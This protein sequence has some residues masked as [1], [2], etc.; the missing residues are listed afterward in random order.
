MFTEQGLANLLLF[1]IETASVTEH[2]T[3]LPPRLQKLWEKRCDYLR[4]RDKHPENKELTNEQLFEN[5]AGLHAEFGR[6]VCVSV[7]MIRFTDGKPKLIQKAIYGENEQEILEKTFKIMEKAVK[8]NAIVKLCG[9]NIKRF[10]IPFLGKRAMINGIDLP[11]ILKVQ[12]KKPWEIMLTDT[13]DLWSFGA[14]QEGFVA[15]DLIAACLGLPSPK[16][17]MDGSMVSKA[18]WSGG[19][20]NIARYCDKDV[21]ALAQILLKLSKKPDLLIEEAV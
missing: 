4:N 2:Y 21:L 16:D 13:S 18:Y 6:V 3:D 7:G 11:E 14:W 17:E 19:V 15:L 12:D 5:T 10:D 20:S 1:D 8:D 9:H